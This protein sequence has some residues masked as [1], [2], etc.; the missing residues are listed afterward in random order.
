MQADN[1]HEATWIRDFSIEISRIKYADQYYRTKVPNCRFRALNQFNNTS[2]KRF[3]NDIGQER[4]Y[5]ILTKKAN[6]NYSNS[7]TQS[8][9]RINQSKKKI[10]WS[11]H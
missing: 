3:I 4:W 11:K 7:K 8:L 6:L 2:G 1:K 9:L 5:Y 10:S